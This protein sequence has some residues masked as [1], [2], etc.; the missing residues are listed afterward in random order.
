M[1]LP[2]RPALICKS[3]CKIP[4]GSAKRTP[5]PCCDLVF[6]CVCCIRPG[7]KGRAIVD[8]VAGME[9]IV[10]SSK[11]GRNS[12]VLSGGSREDCYFGAQGSNK[13][14]NAGCSNTIHGT[15]IIIKY[16]GSTSVVQNKTT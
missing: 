1:S 15:N 12:L 5:W 14:S 9:L 2:I 4:T 16:G 11:I 13:R 8:I 6:V 10:S 3:N 7:N